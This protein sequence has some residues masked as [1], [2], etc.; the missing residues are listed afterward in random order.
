MDS[1]L[2]ST[3][4]ISHDE[5]LDEQ[6]ELPMKIQVTESK[7][8][9]VNIGGSYQTYYGFGL[10]FGWENR[11]IGGMGNRLSFQGDVTQR[12]HSGVATYLLPDFKRIGQDFVWQA[13][14]YHESITAYS[15]RTYNLATRLERKISKRLRIAIGGKAER[16]YV[17]ASADN[18]RF[19]LLEVPL[20]LRWSTA[21]NLL[22][23]TRGI[24]IEYQLNPVAD[25][26]HFG[27]VYLYQELT[28]SAY[29]PV[30][31]SEFLVLAQKITFGSILSDGLEA[32][33]IPKRF[34]G[35]SEEDLRGYRYRTVSPLRGDKPI[36]GRS[37]IYYTFETRF[38]VSPT[39]GLVPFF[40]MG[41][42]QLRQFPTFQGEW[43]KSVGLGVR[44]FSFMGPF[45]LDVGF[46]LNR[47]K[48][49]HDPAYRIL[50]SVGQSF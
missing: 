41:N 39:I 9:S 20:Y 22:N 23:P 47:R 5:V 27:K 49:I 17:T 42:V 18:G 26:E 8:R 15:E 28:Q 10:T 37:A 50:V 48:K 1:G 19:S 21:N 11:N 12:S 14:A 6:C 43:F 25:L 31:K 46:P 36:G 16:L 44:Y 33:P 29:W 35:G 13:Q 30:V 38:R 7:H 45:R 24:G 2:F 32:V 4:V 34:L 40:D 3:V